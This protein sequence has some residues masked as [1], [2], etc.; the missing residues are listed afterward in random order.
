MKIE[1]DPAAD[2]LYLTLRVH[3]RVAETLEPTPGINVDV[4][5]KGHPVGVEILYAVRR[6]GR[7]ALTNIGLDLSGLEWSPVQNRFLSTNEA[8]TRLG[9]SRQ[10]IGRLA[11]AGRL[12]ARRAGRDWLIPESGL[13][14]FGRNARRKRGRRPTIA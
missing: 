14:N 8:A 4:D 10:Y 7:D 11:R 12:S 3:A 13:A 5:A 6:L 2:A 1:Y 9:V